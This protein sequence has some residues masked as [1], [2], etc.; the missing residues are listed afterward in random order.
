VLVDL[1]DAA[2]ARALEER[3]PAVSAEAKKVRTR[4][5]IRELRGR[6]YCVDLISPVPSR[7][8]STPAHPRDDLIERLTAG[9]RAAKRYAR[10]RKRPRPLPLRAH[11]VRL[12][13]QPR[14]IGSISLAVPDARN[15]V[16]NGPASA[17]CE[18]D[19]STDGR[20]CRWLG[21]AGSLW[22]VA[23]AIITVGIRLT[24]APTPAF[25]RRVLA[26]SLPEA[27]FDLRYFSG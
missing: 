6:G 20:T 13:S 5:M 17:R 14:S 7:E 3:A 4:T 27:P 21:V 16:A 12:R 15:L 1:E 19:V 25:T 23:T 26:P 9:L 22:I 11:V 18:R 2:R 24:A 10:I 8:G